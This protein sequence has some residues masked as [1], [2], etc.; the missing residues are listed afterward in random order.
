MREPARATV[1]LDRAA[2]IRLAVAAAG[3]DDAILVAGKGH[4]TTQTIGERSERFD[5][6]AAV[7]AALGGAS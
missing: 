6:V 7:R 4:E 3:A 2:A 5:D 1:E